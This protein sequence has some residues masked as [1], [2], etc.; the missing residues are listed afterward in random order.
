MHIAKIHTTL[1]I[2]TETSSIV[3]NAESF[4]CDNQLDQTRF[5]ILLRSA[6]MP[7]TGEPIEHNAFRLAALWRSTRY[8][9]IEDFQYFSVLLQ[10]MD[11]S[12]EASYVDI[13]LTWLYENMEIIYG[14]QSVRDIVSISAHRS[15]SL[16]PKH[17]VVYVE[18]LHV[19]SMKVNV[20]FIGKE[21]L[22]LQASEK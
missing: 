8:Q 21:S 19:N 22:P 18:L 6:P 17:Q 9:S 20:S 5:P 3:I 12:V 10:E 4:Q 16:L 2:S 15:E 13:L 11:L 7:Q 1:E 14:V